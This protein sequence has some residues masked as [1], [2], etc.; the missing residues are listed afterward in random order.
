MYCNDIQLKNTAERRAMYEK[1]KD[2]Y[3]PD[4]FTKNKEKIMLLEDTQQKGKAD[5]ATLFVEGFNDALDGPAV[6]LAWHEGK[7]YYAC[8]PNI[9]RIAGATG[10]DAKAGKMDVLCDGM[11]VRVGISGHDVHGTVIGPDGKLYWSIGDRG[12]STTSKEGK[13]F[14]IH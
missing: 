14:S 9:W 2:K 4:Y 3:K 8:C 5:K 6:G 7:L 13:V 11:G 1:Y 12:Y 10:T